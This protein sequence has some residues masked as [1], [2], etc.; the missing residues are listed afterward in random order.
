MPWVSKDVIAAFNMTEEE[1]RELTE[2]VMAL[3]DAWQLEARDQM[4]LLGLDPNTR[5]RKL[6]SYRRGNPLPENEM[7]LKRA[8]DLVSVG[9]ALSNIF[10]HSI[11]SANLWVTTHQVIFG[12]RTPL[13][14]MLEDH[15]K[16]IERI[17]TVL[18]NTGGW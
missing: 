1:R 6:I 10:P 15:D 13:E 12:Q 5:S 17:L 8:T 7:I 14:V 2:S 4:C 9:N 16:G 18:D 3:L 11:H